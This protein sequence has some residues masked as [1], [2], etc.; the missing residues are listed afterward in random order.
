VVAISAA[1]GEG[2]PALKAALAGL[3]PSGDE[4]DALPEPSG[5]VVHRLDA[6]P[7]RVT[8]RRES[9]GVF[10]VI[11]RRIERLASQTNFEIEESAER[12]QR[13]LE[14]LGADAAL[15]GAGIQPGDTVLV[16]AVELA[17]EAEAWST[18]R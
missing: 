8:V 16:G 14:R 4:A 5:V 10:R 6:A 11:G 7:D 9:A 2:V 13:D 18:R 3:L 17:W 1:I 15:R 12:F